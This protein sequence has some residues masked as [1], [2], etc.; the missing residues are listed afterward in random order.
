MTESRLPDP[1]ARCRAL[2]IAFGIA[3][4]VL[5]PAQTPA[6]E[7]ELERVTLFRA[8]VGFFEA[9]GVPHDARPSTTNGAARGRR[10]GSGSPG[11]MSGRGDGPRGERELLFLFPTRDPT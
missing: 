9:R 8:G 6:G 2:A 5:A 3:L 4:A 11:S 7:L 10:C 1:A